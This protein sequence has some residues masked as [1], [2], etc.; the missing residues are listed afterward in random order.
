MPRPVDVGLLDSWQLSL[1]DKSPRT[2]QMY[3]GVLDMF[4]A[5][6]VDTERPALHEVTRRD[7]EGWFTEQRE[8]GRAKATMRSRWIALRSFYNWA[9]LEDEVDANPME[10]VKVSRAEPDPPDVLTD[11][12]LRALLKATEGRSF[13]ERRDHAIIRTMVAAGLRASELVGLRLDDVDLASRIVAVH[14]AKGDRM[15]YVRIDP[16]TAA[17]IDRYKRVRARHRFADRPN[18]WV[19]HRGPM[20]RK[21]LG[22]MLVKRAEQAGIGHV[23]P[24]QLRHTWAHRYL[25]RGGQE[26]DL[27][28]LGGWENTDVMRRYGSAMAADRALAAYDDV[29]P[30]EGL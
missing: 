29:A 1:H 9:H 12:D 2:V 14:H 10:R 5:W 26:G 30:M 25:R 27:Q 21:G 20:T 24:H 19:G 22:P 23:H 4:A 8:A 13:N 28:R 15:R 16:T 6:L 11:D 18:L 17:A 7:C 3:R